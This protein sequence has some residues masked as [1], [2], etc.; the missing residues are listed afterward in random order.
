MKKPIIR[1]VTPEIAS[2][3]LTH[4][5][6][7]NLM[8]RSKVEKYKKMMIAGK[9]KNNVGTPIVI[10]EGE[11]AYLRPGYTPFPLERRTYFALFNEDKLYYCVQRRR[12]VMS[13]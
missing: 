5:R 6:K 11:M 12:I 8:S 9:W 13:V 7:N 3:L 10:K 2:E 1:L 4:G